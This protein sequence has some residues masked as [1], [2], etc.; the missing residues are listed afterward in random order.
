MDAM[1]ANPS[2]PEATMSL[3]KSGTMSNTDWDSSDFRSPLYVELLR[4]DISQLIIVTGYLLICE[5]G[6]Y[7]FRLFDDSP[8]SQVVLLA[9]P[10]A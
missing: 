2:H 6:Y 8:L 3:M 7:S 1:A 9:S 10:H 4:N 5:D